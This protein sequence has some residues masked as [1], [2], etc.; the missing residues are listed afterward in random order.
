MVPEKRLANVVR[1]DA[2]ARMEKNVI[3]RIAIANNMSTKPVAVVVIPTYNEAGSIGEMIDTLCSKIFPSINDWDCQ[4]LIVDDTSPD[5]TYKIVEEKQKKYKNLKLY[6]NPTKAG[7]GGAYVKGFRYAMKEMGADVLIEFD[8]DFQHPPETI[9]LLL[10]EINNGYDYVTGS[11]KI[12]G[13]SVPKSWDFQRKFFTYFG[14]FVARFILFFPFKYFFQVTD[15][16]TGLKASRVKGFVDHLDMDH[17][18]SKNFGYKL[19]FF[20]QMT[21]FKAKVKEIPLQ[22]GLRQTGVSKISG[23]TARDILFTC[24]NLRWHDPFVQKFLKFGLVGGLG[25]VINFLGLKFF[26]GIY[27]NILPF[28][29]GVVN[30]LA[31]ATASELS[32]INNFTWNNLWTFKAEKITSPKELLSKFITFN[33]S[34]IVGGILVPSGV[35]GLGTQIFGDQ[36]RSILLV[37]AVFGFTIPYNWFIYNVFIWKKKK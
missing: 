10:R 15:P 33:L 21:L 27:K 9:P 12:A 23:N 25:F 24:I 37:I 4:L 32:I 8:G 36:Y 20:F 18:Y 1:V 2:S 34:S 35:I 11:R 5:G 28:P 13:G 19:E 7:I 30:F 29:I 31:N 14:G 6:L 16:T 22:F 26:N 17:L 3:V